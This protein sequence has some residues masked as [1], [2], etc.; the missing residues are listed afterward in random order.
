M[1]LAERTVRR[2]LARLGPRPDPEAFLPSYARCG[3]PR[4][5]H[6]DLYKASVRLR[7]DNPGW[8]AGRICV[9]LPQECP[10]RDAPAPR[11]V[12]RWLAQAGLAPKPAI[13]RP[14]EDDRRATEPHQVWQMD[15]CEQI[16]LGDA[17]RASWLRGFD[18]CSGAVL[19]TDVF[20]P[21]ALGQGRG[22]PD[23]GRDASGLLALGAA[24]QGA[25]R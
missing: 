9:S 13:L 8:G 21:R 24:G 20:P 7:L 6:S 5:C 18:E 17:T 19:W 2:L 10:G 14:P 1:R 25:R 12:R 15:A 3:Q 16:P 23:A 22:G 4:A 11:L